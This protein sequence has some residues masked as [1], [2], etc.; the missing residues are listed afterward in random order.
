MKAHDTIVVK[1]LPLAVIVATRDKAI[2]VKF[3]EGMRFET[4]IPKSVIE[5]TSS[6]DQLRHYREIQQHTATIKR[7]FLEKEF[8]GLAENLN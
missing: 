2:C 3:E 4:W 7:W 1:E 8:K 6:E 5:I